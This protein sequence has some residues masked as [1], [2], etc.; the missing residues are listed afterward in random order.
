MIGSVPTVM[1]DSTD[2]CQIFLSKQSLKTEI[3]SS[4]SSEMNVCVPKGQDYTEIPIPEQ[5]KTVIKGRKM[6]TM[7]TESV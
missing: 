1:I 3:V 6:T 4:K 2:G 7:P 5:F